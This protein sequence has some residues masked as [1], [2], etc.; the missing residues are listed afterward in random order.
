MKQSDAHDLILRRR[1]SLWIVLSVP[2]RLWYWLPRILPLQNADVSATV[3]FSL[4]LPY[5]SQ[6]V[7]VVAGGM[8]HADEM[9][10]QR[11]LMEEPVGRLFK[12]VIESR[13]L[14]R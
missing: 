6:Q 11:N 10:G 14:C 1:S 8:G 9:R 3:P 12:K 7:A 13:S 4:L 5:C 2:R